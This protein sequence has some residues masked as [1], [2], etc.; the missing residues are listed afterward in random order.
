MSADQL[1]T[2]GLVRRVSVSP[3]T[4]P[5]RQPRLGLVAALAAAFGVAVVTGVPTDLIDTPLFGRAIAPAGW[6][7]PVWIASSVLVGL[8]VARDGR[9]SRAAAGGGLLALLA[10]GCPV[11]NKAVVLALGSAGAVEWFSPAQPV[12]AV[13]SVAGLLA[14]LALGAGRRAFPV[15]QDVRPAG[16]PSRKA[17][18]GAREGLC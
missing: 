17:P 9:V 1:T 13:L 10:V 11:C 15:A 2:L 16:S 7:Y 12:L 18:T 4:M 14:A 5:Q 8:L 3:G 6:A